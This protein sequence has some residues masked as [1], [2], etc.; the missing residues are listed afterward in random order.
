MTALAT[1]PPD[2]EARIV[3]PLRLN[4]ST[5]PLSLIGADLMPDEVRAGRRLAYLKRRLVFGLVAL[6]L[7]IGL[8]DALARQQT[9][10]A[11]DDLAVAQQRITNLNQ[12]ATRFG[13]VV[14]VQTQTQQLTTLLSQAMAG[15][16]PW[17][18]LTGT[19][20]RLAPRGLTL[21]GL[22]GT[23]GTGS[24][25]AAPVAPVAGAAPAPAAPV[26]IGTLSITGNADGYRAVADYVSALVKVRGLTAVTPATAT[27]A[28][29]GSA[30]TFT[31]TASLT[32][33]AQDGR[34]AASS[35]STTSAAT[36]GAVTPGGS[37]APAAA[38]TGATAPPAATS[39]TANAPV[40]N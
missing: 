26:V 4:T 30:L 8:G 27:A 40:G 25:P 18:T 33:A 39:T 20:Q 35:P 37:A 12:Q 11:Q 15:D 24:A 34:Y 21:T 23:T 17:A 14:T 22:D 13:A 10:S 6:A 2:A 5:E 32:T 16:V 9:G 1:P 28:G 38:T 29:T 7:V 36:P 31:I 3:T 19:L